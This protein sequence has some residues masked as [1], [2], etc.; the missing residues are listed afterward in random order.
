VTFDQVEPRISS[1]AI[2]T[3][4]L[5]DTSPIDIEVLLPLVPVAELEM[6]LAI[7][8]AATV[9]ES[10]TTDMER[11]LETSGLVMVETSIDKIKSW[12]PEATEGDV[13]PRPRRKA[14]IAVATPDEPL[15]MVE[16]NR[17]E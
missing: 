14:T 17:L 4:T 13:I 3:S 6:P 7:E 10:P 9:I 16:T 8:P 15:V 5:T 2:P 12:L 11:V 1:E